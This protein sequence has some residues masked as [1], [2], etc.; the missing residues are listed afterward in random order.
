VNGASEAPVEELPGPTIKWI[1][2]LSRLIFGG[3]WLYSGVMPFID[4]AWQPLG[5]EQ[6]ARDFTIA[7]IDSGLMTW[8][9]IAEI[10]LGILILAN[11]MMVF[12]AIAIVPINFVILY[13]NFVLDE[14]AVEYTFGVLTVLFN[15]ILLWPWRRYYWRLFTWRGRPDFSTEPGIQD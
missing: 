3:W 15:I 5:Q 13:W 8:V 7:L 10:A 4:P 11:R 9:K 6:A 2:H 14:G 1:Y 12:A